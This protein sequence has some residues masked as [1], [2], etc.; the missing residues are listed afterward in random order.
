MATRRSPVFATLS[1]IACSTES[2]TRTAADQRIGLVVGWVLTVSTICIP[3]T[4]LLVP[5]TAGL[6]A[7]A[8]WPEARIDACSADRQCIVSTMPENALPVWVAFIWVA[9]IAVALAVCWKPE[10]WWLPNAQ[11]RRFVKVRTYTSPDWI[12]I[13]AII[14]AG[15]SFGVSFGVVKSGND[16]SAPEY[17]WPAGAAL[18]IVAVATVSMR[19][20]KFATPGDVRR[21]LFLT[22]SAPVAFWTPA[23]K[24]EQERLH[25][26]SARKKKVKKN[27]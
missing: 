10:R 9:I 27:D 8:T 15:I 22:L 21:S 26:R 6:V 11:A 20:H 12:R 16:V 7:L 2:T 18:V 5:A 25:P 24:A 19:I 1:T 17:L 13:H 3:S 4:L 23:W 14:A